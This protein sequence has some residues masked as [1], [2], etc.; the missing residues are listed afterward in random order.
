MKK[1]ISQFFNYFICAL[2]VSIVFGIVIAIEFYGLFSPTETMF[3]VVPTSLKWLLLIGTIPYLLYINISLRY[4]KKENPILTF[5]VFALIIFWPLFLDG[6]KFSQTRDSDLRLLIYEI[7]ILI[8]ETWL[9]YIINDQNDT[10]NE[11]L[12]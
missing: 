3:K 8:G 1:L 11:N 4:F 12:K 6:Y 7:I 5:I 10:S 9:H 2:S